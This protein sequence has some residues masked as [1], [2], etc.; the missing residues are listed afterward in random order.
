MC[1]CVYNTRCLIRFRKV[2]MVRA[3]SARSASTQLDHAWSAHG[4][5]ARG[6]H[7]TSTWPARG[8]HMAGIWSAHGQHK[9]STRPRH[10]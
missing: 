4:Q 5:S 6:R 8:R 9:A 1:V 10:G 7:M 3:C 2:G